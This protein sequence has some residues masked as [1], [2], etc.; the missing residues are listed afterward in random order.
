VQPREVRYFTKTG[1]TS[2]VFRAIGAVTIL[3]L[4]ELPQS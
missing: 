1:A 4:V 2:V 3:R